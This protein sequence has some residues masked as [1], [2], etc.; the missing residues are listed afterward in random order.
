MAQAPLIGIDLGTSKVAVTVGYPQ[1]HGLDLVGVGFAPTHGMRRGTVVDVEEVISSI[2]AALEEAERMSGQPITQATVSI[3]GEHI[4]C[5]PSR[6][7]VAVLRPDASITDE[8]VFRVLDAAKSVSVPANR[9]VLSATARSYNVDG[10]SDV[11][12]PVGMQGIRLEVEAQVVSGATASIKT[13]L[14]CVEQ[15]T[16]HP[17]ELVFTPLAAAKAL[18]TR[19]EMEVGCVLLDLGASTTSFAVFE[20]GEL[21]HAGVIPVGGSHVT[22]DI[23]IGLRTSLDAAEL[24][25]VHHATAHAAD[26]AGKHLAWGK[27]GETGEEPIDLSFVAQIVEARLIEVLH[28]LREELRRV[29][30]DGMLPAGVILTGGGAK[31]VGL[32]ELAKHTLRLP[33]RVGSLALEVSGMVDNVG[34]PQYAASIGLMLWAH[35]TPTSA[36]ASRRG[37]G[38]KPLSGAL[39]KAKSALRNLLP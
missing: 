26:A 37:G 4:Q 27:V 25:K 30:R 17:V 28:L 12:D 39:G 16:V 36:P 1:E 29:G 7:V 31:Q 15:A 33:V 23:A 3:G 21:V 32:V 10:T 6:G 9:E 5:T 22:N 24:I 11:R 20:E 19:K 34:D 2:A 38:P 8:D 14:R 13:L 18:L 35:E